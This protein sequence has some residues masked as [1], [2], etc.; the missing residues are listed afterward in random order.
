MNAAAA[1]D[2]TPFGGGEAMPTVLSA[3]RLRQSP[4][5]TPEAVTVIDRRMIE[6]TG[7]RELPELLR[8]V[9]GM[10]AAYNTGNDAF[11][12]YQGTSADDARRMQVLV[13]GR[14]VYQP[15]LASVDWV[16]FPVDLAD[17]DRIEVI[18]GPSAS[19]WGGNSFLGVVNIITRHPADVRGARAY[20]RN[21]QDGINDYFA[22]IG[23]GN[24]RS[25]WRVSSSGRADGGFSENLK[26]ETAYHD[27]TNQQGV[28]VR[29]EI[30]FDDRSSVDVSFGAA[31]MRAEQERRN[32][33]SIY[34]A[35]P[36]AKVDNDFVNLAWTFDVSPEHTLHMQ[37]S[38]THFNHDEPWYVHL[39]RVIVSA[40]LGAM[41]KADPVYTQAFFDAFANGDPPPAPTAAALP[42]VLALNTAIANDPAL[43]DE[44]NYVS[45]E[46]ISERRSTAE[47]SDTWVPNDRLRVVAGAGWDR[48][49]A[50]SF[51]YLGG[52]RGDSIYRFFANAE[53][54]MHEKWLLNLGASQDNDAV[55]GDYFSPRAALNWIFTDNQVLRAVVARGVRLPNIIETSTN[56]A[57]HVQAENPA[58]SQYNGIYFQTAMSPGTAPTETILAHELSYYANIAPAHTTLDV[59]VY[60]NKLNLTNHSI[61]LDNFIISPLYSYHMDG[62]ESA[63][64]W[65]P[66]PSQ[67]LQLNYAYINVD[68]NDE[69]TDFVPNQSGTMGWWQDYENGWQGSLV[70]GIYYNLHDFYYDRLDARLAHRFMLGNRQQ[71]ELSLNAR[72]HFTDHPEL[73]RENGDPRSRIWVMADWR[74]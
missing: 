19:V 4:L 23:F 16:N 27:S 26:R 72:H 59:K 6:Q 12:G 71:L 33:I 68:G 34:N 39:P 50:N 53:W 8:L 40:P 24:E 9:P 45:D 65:Q 66:L 52:S 32:D 42:Y 36:V 18:R 20:Y 44:S 13:D 57:F 51:T 73:R 29:G 46:S 30:R 11:V 22:R 62:I 10:V 74:Y 55:A 17:I 56:W 2:E 15:A 14:P 60:R 49:E 41:W 47:L 43:L 38:H 3:T 5:E 21:G 69:N 35:L 54:R 1:D 48:M 25:D 7:V 31:H 70:Y 28:N 67:R 61:E 63:I 64:D 58:E 37:A